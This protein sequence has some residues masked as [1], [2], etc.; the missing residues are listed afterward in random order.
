MNTEAFGWAWSVQGGSPALLLHLARPLTVW[1][2]IRSD[3]AGRV[4]EWRKARPK[5]GLSAFR[6]FGQG[7]SLGLAIASLL[8]PKEQKAD[9]RRHLS[10]TISR[11]RD[12]STIR[13]RQHDTHAPSTF[14]NKQNAADSRPWVEGIWVASVRGLKTHDPAARHKHAV[15]RLSV[16][17]GERG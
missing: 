10:V 13:T 3:C 5:R 7:F 14:H 11:G 12:L 15:A 2:R 17:L 6:S 8:S 1:L 4:E 16:L 9:K